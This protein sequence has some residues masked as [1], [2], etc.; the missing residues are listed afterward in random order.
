[1]QKN[2]AEETTNTQEP[3]IIL[4]NLTNFVNYSHFLKD[5][6]KDFIELD[7]IRACL[8]VKNYECKQEIERYKQHKF[9]YG[10]YSLDEK[11]TLIIE[12]SGKPFATPTDLGA[13][14]KENFP[15]LASKLYEL[16]GI[17]IDLDY[18]YNEAIII[19]VD[20]KE[21]VVLD[22]PTNNYIADIRRL[23]K[24]HSDKYAV[25]NYPNM[26]HSDGLVIIQKKGSQFYLVIYNKGI[27]LR[28]ARNHEY[29]A[30]FKADYITETENML[31]LE[32]QF[33]KFEGMRKAFGIEKDGSHPKLRD[34]LNSK[35]I[36][37]ADALNEVIG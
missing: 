2:R 4:G 26:K 17:N 34:M 36:I 3:N 29:F 13:I 7:K 9:R 19:R 30:Q 28:K 21:D 8:P 25:I 12:V 10:S 6:K 18:L 5:R 23:A 33:T 37:I 24:M 16:S 32:R 15:L 35:K 14:N 20:V 22:E 1:M 11:D 27:E 31:R